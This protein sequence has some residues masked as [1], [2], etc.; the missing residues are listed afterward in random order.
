[1]SAAC[2]SCGEAVDEA[3]RFCS[4]CGSRTY[5]GRLASAKL[6][7]G[8][9][10]NVTVLFADMVGSTEMIDGRDPEDLID[11]LA[12][13]RLAIREA[14][15]RFDGFVLHYLGDGVVCCF[16][17]PL[18]RED[19]AER[20]VHAALEILSAVAT[21]GAREAPIQVRVGV[22]SGVVVAMENPATNR[23]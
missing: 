12:A 3:A 20:A 8:E 21:L 14:V 23:I 15:D 11:G 6:A 2:P 17:Y 16:G 4:A 19:S 1:M 22:A 18:A 5:G 13:Y 7:Q 9:R 10:R